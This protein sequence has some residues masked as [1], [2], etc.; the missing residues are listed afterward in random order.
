MKQKKK[1]PMTQYYTRKKQLHYI[2]SKWE[3]MKDMGYCQTHEGVGPLPII[4]FF[5]CN[6]SE[7]N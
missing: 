2:G 5:N 7:N 4:I 1:N 3:G 6:S